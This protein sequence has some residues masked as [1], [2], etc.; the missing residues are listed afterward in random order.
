MPL[1]KHFW[2]KER[3]LDGAGKIP[4][5]TTLAAAGLFA[6][7]FAAQADV[8]KNNALFNIYGWQNW[9]WV[10]YD[11]T[12]GKDYDEVSG[13]AANIGLEANFDTGMSGIMV[14]LK[15]ESW[16]LHNNWS[17]SGGWCTR[18]SKLGLEGAFGEI[19][20]A[21]WLLPYNEAV[22]QTIDPFYDAGPT[23]HTSIMGGIGG[24]SI[25]HS[26]GLWHNA[27]V[28]Y[29]THNALAHED[30][31]NNDGSEAF[32]VFPRAGLRYGVG[33]DTGLNRRQE[34]IIQYFSPVMN[35]FKFRFAMT[36]GR[37]DETEVSNGLRDAEG[38]LMK[39]EVDPQIMSGS[40]VYENGPLWL[41]AT[42]Q[43]HEDWTAS[44]PNT[45][46][47]GTMLGSDTES[48]RL[49]GRYIFEMGGDMKFHLAVM[50]E[51]IEYEF[52][53]VS[54]FDDALGGFLLG[55]DSYTLDL[56]DVADRDAANVATAGGNVKIDRDAYLVSGKL[57]FNESVDFRFSY[58]DADELEVSCG[59]CT[60]DWAETD[61]DSYN[62]GLFY[63]T[64][65]KT[66]FRV[67]YTEVDNGRNSSY[68]TGVN[69]VGYAKAGNK[70]ELL[71][72]G[73]V[74]WFD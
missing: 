2:Q 13:N 69:G 66:E 40:L 57:K 12:K 22:A 35:G 55:P 73:I 42:W 74:Q 23:S 61:A 63:T 52:N 27:R 33:L 14:N 56:T 72:F 29:A 26:P 11:Q 51:D 54:S 15:C 34:D 45:L 41:A 53:Q 37:E 64:P 8:V 18:N 30:P 5:L 4:Y 16:T 50:Y 43:E 3:H 44:R 17:G 21:T 58:M 60:G 62:I 67:T 6:G 19:M 59:R 9:S 25:Y 36:S 68:A 7:S 47:R 46:L 39:R 32:N 65:N 10:T 71:S 70:V 20:F 38:D 1:T 49:A 31:P 24:S 28:D 48:W